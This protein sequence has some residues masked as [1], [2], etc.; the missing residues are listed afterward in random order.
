MLAQQ[1]A[2]HFYR[3]HHVAMRHYCLRNFTRFYSCRH[4]A[5]AELK[6]HGVLADKS[7]P[8]EGE[9][10]KKIDTTDVQGEKEGSF[11]LDE[12]DDEGDF[13]LSADNGGDFG[14]SRTKT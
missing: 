11:E 1:D 6:H 3:H 7:P 4:I 8:E 9:E 10:N 12:G 14:E 13:E 2:L 5:G